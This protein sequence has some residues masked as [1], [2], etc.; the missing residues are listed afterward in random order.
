MRDVDASFEDPAA[1]TSGLIDADEALDQLAE[2]GFAAEAEMVRKAGTAAAEPDWTM[3]G[4]DEDA[5]EDMLA[6]FPDTVADSLQTPF[7]K[8]LWGKITNW[9]KTQGAFV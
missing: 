7:A 4:R 9:V 2:G 8:N 6:V 5:K 1:D 3:F